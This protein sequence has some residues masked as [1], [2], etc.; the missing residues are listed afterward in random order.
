MA[1]THHRHGG[2]TDY[3][4]MSIGVPAVTETMIRSAAAR[5]GRDDIVVTVARP[6]EYAQVEALS[7]AADP[8]EMITP[9]TANV[10]AW[11]VDQNPCG[12]GFMVI[13]RDRSTGTVIGYFLFYPWRLV[14][15]AEG[16]PEPLPSFLYVRLY[17]APEYRRRR[18]FAAMTSFG[19]DLV[20][21]LGVGLAYTVPNPRSTAGFLKFSMAHAG[22]LP[23]WIR[24]VA[25]GWG[26]LAARGART[27][28]LTVSRCQ[29]FAGAA[30][31]EIG[32]MLPESTTVWSPRAVELLE[33]R[34][35]RHPECQYE[36]R[37]IQRDERPIG[38]VI[39]RR[40]RIKRFRT[41]VVCDA[42]FSESGSSVLRLA[43]EDALR[44]G[45]TVD[46][47]IAFG[48]DASPLYRKAL[49][50]A[51]FLVCPTFLQPQPVAILGGGVGDPGQRIELPGVSTWHITPYDW[52]VF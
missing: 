31:P 40:M 39:T 49:R 41:M 50:R 44:S 38:C 9:L 22:S 3:R 32:A 48:G 25:P 27:R 1:F 14:H 24:P 23:F 47:A 34:Y 42:W 7:R 17:V 30:L 8:T 19:L 18:V 2:S 10:I 28:G 16:L 4:K 26:W 11:F 29:G 43:V 52:D 33:W 13:T 20:A 21:Q 36:G 6:D 5:L 51:G 12:R 37:V 15:R 46:L 45:D 35:D